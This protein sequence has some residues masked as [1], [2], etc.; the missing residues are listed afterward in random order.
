MSGELVKSVIDRP[1]K[2]GKGNKLQVKHM[3]P[4]YR[5]MARELLAGTRPVQ[6]AKMF[7]ITPQMMSRIKNSD[8]FVEYMDLL[9]RGAEIRAIEA[10]QEIGILKLR[11][12]EVMDEDLALAGNAKLTADKDRARKLRQSAA[13]DIMDR[14]PDTSRKHGDSVGGKHLH[15]HQHAHIEKMSDKELADEVFKELEIGD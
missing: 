3:N 4:R 7:G 13:K 5:A 12:L 10:K 2:V 15:F 8:V 1:A 14:C 11:A 6:V 9:E